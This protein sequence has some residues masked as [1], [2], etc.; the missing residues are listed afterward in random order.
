MSKSFGKYRVM[1]VVL[2]EKLVGVGSKNFLEI[3]RIC[4]NQYAE[5][6][7]LHTFAQ[8]TSHSTGIG[9]GDRTV[10]NMVF[11][12][13]SDYNIPNTIRDDYN[14]SDDTEDT[15]EIEETNEDVVDEDLWGKE[16]DEQ[17]VC[18]SCG[19]KLPSNAVM[20]DKCGA[21]L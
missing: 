4:N 7:R 12:R 13:I 19:A 18:P 21:L 5:G 2:K 16:T 8:S 3:E 9:G 20:C 15:E 6:Y 11:E 1:Q 14:D 10:C 17:I